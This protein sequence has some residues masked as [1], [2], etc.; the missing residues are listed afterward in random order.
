M[1]YSSLFHWKIIKA[2]EENPIVVNAGETATINIPVDG[3]PPPSASWMHDG[4]EI[5]PVKVSSH[6]GGGRENDKYYGKTYFK[7]AMEFQRALT[8]TQIIEEDFFK[9]KRFSFISS[10]W[11]SVLNH[12]YLISRQDPNPFLCLSFSTTEPRNQVHWKMLLYRSLNV[13]AQ[14]PANTRQESSITW[15]EHWSRLK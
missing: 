8:I 15:A 9:I 10:I 3:N 6:H 11:A 1:K 7:H 4:E 2:L 14:I 12:Y 13:N 5:L